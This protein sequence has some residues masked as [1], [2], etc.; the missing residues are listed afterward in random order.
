MVCDVDSDVSGAP[1]P[2]ISAEMAGTLDSGVPGTGFRTAASRRPSSPEL[3]QIRAQTAEAGRLSLRWW[4]GC[5]SPF[6]A[7]A[8]PFQEGSS[9][10]PGWD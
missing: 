2:R 8:K 7:P 1:L 10:Q 4:G 6:A 3:R 9:E 5:V